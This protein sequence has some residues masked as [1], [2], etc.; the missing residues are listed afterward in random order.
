MENTRRLINKGL[1]QDRLE[2]RTGWDVEICAI[3][4]QVRQRN[5]SGCLT[6]H[7]KEKPFNLVAKSSKVRRFPP[8]KTLTVALLLSALCL[9]ALSEAQENRALLEALVRKGVLTAAEA[10]EIQAEVRTEQK[11]DPKGK[12]KLSDSV[13]ELALSG[14]LRLRYQY[15]NR[16]PQAPENDAGQ[17]RSR[18]RYRL[19]LN[20]DFKLG[21]DWFGGIQITT[22]RM[23]D[24]GFATYGDGFGNGELAVSRA[25]VGWHAA[26]WATLIFG[27]QP[28]PYFTTDLLWDSE[29][30]PAGITGEFA[31]H[32][33][34]DWSEESPWEISY[35]GGAFVFAENTGIDRDGAYLFENQLR[36]T[37]HFSPT[38]SLTVAPAHLIYNHAAISKA[39]NSQPF[40]RESTAPW[41]TDESANLSLLQLPG[42][43]RFAAW[44]QPVTFLWDAVYN[45]KAGERVLET[46]GLSS[47]A[48]KDDFAFLVGLQIGENKKAGDWSLYS[49]FRQ[50][51]IGAI[52]P[53]INDSSWGLSRLNL[54]GFKSGIAY[55][56]TDFAVGHVNYFTGWNVRKD[57]TGGQATEGAALGDANTVEVLQLELN[58]KF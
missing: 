35:I 57:L 27:K 42:E 3:M 30:N 10:E 40:D 55:S 29:I 1:E 43:F 33:L 14:E 44:E 20:A 51:G 39:R 12:L 9:P 17:H 2:N 18:F 56:F 8:M 6:G 37:R 7:L 21:D 34:L 49:N 31:L 38:S 58:V 23:A 54:R 4:T 41:V 13:T 53:N 5:A 26:D 25:F 50:V 22:S 46:Y 24:S 36:I 48:V 45:L 32:E 19:R 15:D 28:N 52:D 47:H 11:G 16:S